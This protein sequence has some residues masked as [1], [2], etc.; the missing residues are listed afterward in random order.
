[1]VRKLNRKAAEA[2]SEDFSSN[3]LNNFFSNSTVATGQD[4]LELTPVQQI[5][6]LLVQRLY[7]R[8]QEETLRL[9]SP[10]FNYEHPQVQESLKALMNTLSRHIQVEREA[11]E[12]LLQGAVLDALRLALNPL[13]FFDEFLRQ[14]SSLDSLQSSLRYL[15]WQQS[16]TDVLHEQVEQKEMGEPEYL[17]AMLEAGVRSGKIALD[18]TDE[19]IQA[20]EAVL[21]MP[22]GL[23]EEPAT[24]PQAAAPRE[25]PADDFFS[26]ISRMA[27]RTPKPAPRPTPEPEPAQIPEPEPEPAAKVQAPRKTEPD[28]WVSRPAPAEPE[29]TV[30]APRPATVAPLAASAEK[31]AEIK[32]PEEPKKQ[33]EE[34][35]SL[36]MR[37]G[38]ND[39]KPLYEKFESKEPRSAALAQK[40]RPTNIRHYITLNQRFMFVKELF[41]G[42]AAAFNSAL[43]AL[44]TCQSHREAQQ[45][46]RDNLAHK[47]QWQDDS[48]AAQE[49]MAV[50]DHR[51]GG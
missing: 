40:H 8:W 18:S 9:R 41:D 21:P 6:L 2:Y 20:F 37:L 49:F 35:R 25:E 23:I 24:P 10:Y 1:M 48:E 51:F 33:P 13:S 45:W 16:L 4:I 17:L 42:N 28:P 44:D 47:P 38:A 39:K 14:N 26:A 12:P 27:P 15:R 31:P 22:N 7:Q 50:I 19:Y 5:N 11:L 43:D 34:N 46:T 29:P 32:K 36:N 30:P 3:V